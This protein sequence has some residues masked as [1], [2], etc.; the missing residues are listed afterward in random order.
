MVRVVHPGSGSLLFT[1]LGSRSQKGTDPGSESAKLTIRYTF[2][3]SSRTKIIL[4]NNNIHNNTAQ[5]APL[6]AHS[7]LPSLLGDGRVQI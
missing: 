7:Q 4:K 1:H 2:D 6:P 3:L 5:S